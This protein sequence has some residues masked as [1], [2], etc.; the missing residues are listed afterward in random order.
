MKKLQHGCSEDACDILIAADFTLTGDRAYRLAQEIRILAARGSTVGLIQ[1][2]QPDDGRIIAPEIVTCVRRGIAQVVAPETA[3]AAA[4]LVVHEPSCADW[5]LLALRKPKASEGI[6]VCYAAK[7]FGAGPR[8]KAKPYWHHAPVNP[9]VRAGARSRSSSTSGWQLT[10]DD[11]VPALP[12]AFDTPPA[13]TGAPAV[14]WMGDQLGVALT[15]CLQSMG[16][17]PGPDRPEAEHFLLEGAESGPFGDRAT[18]LGPL[19]LDRLVVGLDVLAVLPSQT[20]TDLPDTI[21]ASALAMGVEVVLPTWLEPHYGPG[22]HYAAPDRIAD[23]V[24]A[25]V[26][27]VRPIGRR[28]VAA[29]T[30]A[31]VARC[32][33]PHRMLLADSA[34]QG[35]SSPPTQ[36]PVQTRPTLCLAANGVGVGHLTRLLAIARRMDGDVVFA[37]QVPALEILDSYGF[38]GDY[39]PSAA[40]VGGDFALWDAWFGAHLNRLLERYDPALVVYDGNHPSRGLIGTVATRRDCRLA[41]IRRGMWA[42]TTSAHLGN[43]RWC[44]LVIEP[45]ELAGDRDQGVTAG[46]RHEALQV[47]PIRLLEPEELF[48][49]NE[50]AQRLGL[51]PRRPAALIQLGSGYNRDLLSLLDQIVGLLSRTPG[52]QIAVAEWVNGTIPLTLWPGVKVLRGFPISQYLRAFDFCV[53]AAGYNSFHELIGFSVPTIFLANR[54]PTMDDQFSRAKFA[55]DSAAAFEISENDLH[56]LPDLVKMMMQERPREFLAEHC[57]KL[58]R[59]NGAVTAAQSLQALSRIAEHSTS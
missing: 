7:D 47:D 24:S 41:W 17:T 34:S 39:I 43:A 52:L 48:D 36:L 2:C 45:G 54:H 23:A 9:F 21:I 18:A 22:P 57:R 6:L 49:R 42:N 56:D 53:S 58:S 50:A 37:S 30:P 59:G 40:T 20:T 14:G 4:R 32:Q 27:A 8:F 10:K 19:S 28:D 12:F 38:H 44:D 15:D 11:W 1:F 33:S 13:R 35:I 55:Q 46:L 26:A 5:S 51:D 16:G 3:H 25:A 29:E 31:F